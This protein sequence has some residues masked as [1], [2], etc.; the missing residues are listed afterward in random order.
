[1][2]PAPNWQKLIMAGISSIKGFSSPL[3]GEEGTHCGA[4]GR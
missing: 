4:M 1:M 2:R 3:A